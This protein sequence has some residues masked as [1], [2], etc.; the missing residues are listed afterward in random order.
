MLDWLPD[1]IS[2][3]FFMFNL[4]YIDMQW[5]LYLGEGYPLQLLGALGL[6]WS[7]SIVEF[8]QNWT[9]SIIVS[10]MFN[11]VYLTDQFDIT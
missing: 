11:K 7:K 10:V 6:S 2:L 3:L 5:W 4:G 1:H 9:K 8:F